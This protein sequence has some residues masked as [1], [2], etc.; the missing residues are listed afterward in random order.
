M[1]VAGKPDVP[2]EADVRLES[3][4][5][6]NRKRSRI[7]SGS[8]AYRCVCG[9]VFAVETTA[10][11]ACPTCRRRVGPQAL[12]SPLTDTVSF[13]IPR[14]EPVVDA[15]LVPAN[16]PGGGPAA[17][18][19][20]E[21]AGRRYGHYRVVR[22]LGQGGM[23]AVY[24]AV[25]ESL[26]RYVALKVLH[27]TVRS[28]ADTDQV[29]RLLQEAIAQARVNHPNVVHIYFVGREDKVPFFA[30][31]LVP[32]LTL[33]DRL[34]QGPVPFADMITVAEQVIEALRHAAEF[35]IVHG[36]VKPSNILTVQENTVKLS[37]FGLARRLSQI[38]Q[39]PATVAGTPNYLSPEAAEGGVS[40]IRSDIYS[41]G[42]T[43]FELSFGRLPYSFSGHNLKEFARVHRTAAIEFPD[44]WPDSVPESWREVLSSLMAK[45]PEDRPQ[46]YEAVLAAIRPFRPI[47]L[48]RA[49][50][51]Q[52]G[53]AWLVD[54]ALAQSLQGVFYTDLPA[55]ISDGGVA[56]RLLGGLPLVLLGAGVPALAAAVQM[57]WKTTPGKRLFQLRIVDRHGMTPTATRLGLRSV[58]Q[59]LPVWAWSAS[60]LYSLLGREVWAGTTVAAVVLWLLADATSALFRRD[61][62]SLHD[63]LT[64][65][66]VVL[67]VPE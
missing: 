34:R 41:L 42:I 21:R 62:T 36:D 27:E 40:D 24:E 54:L 6:T 44:P 66:R 33:A 47:T 20:D 23:G 50:R 22:Q 11:G 29:Q 12:Q 17:A 16:E 37:D 64:Q 35:D 46:T 19:R 61:G 53:L 51:V 10:G 8:V 39:D 1:G 13:R 25:D 49:G 3:L 63:L 48:P 26:Q 43:L 30:M 2:G 28:A 38:G 7:L 59:F 56:G 5:Y 4:T 58:F 18:E 31:E 65:T 14:D 67:D 45:S 9:A 52:R 60:G 57:R 32:G 15:E 55:I